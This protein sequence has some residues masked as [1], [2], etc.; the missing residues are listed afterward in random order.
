MLLTRYSAVSHIDNLV[1]LLHV[2]SDSYARG[3]YNPE[4]LCKVSFRDS[5]IPNIFGRMTCCKVTLVLVFLQSL[6]FGYF[7]IRKLFPKWENLKISNNTINEKDR[8]Y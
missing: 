3:V 7:Y 5:R 4:Q 1:H 8:Y 2:T 6:T